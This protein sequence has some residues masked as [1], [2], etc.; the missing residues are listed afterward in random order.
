MSR[1]V[2]I[3]GNQYGKWL[4]IGPYRREKKQTKWF[5]RC[6]GCDQ[7][8]QWVAG[9]TLKNG[10]STG[11]RQC[12]FK[13]TGKKNSTHGQ[14]KSRL[15]NVFCNIIAR[16]EVES[17]I[18][19][20]RYGGRGIKLCPEWRRDFEAFSAYVGEPPTADHEIDRIDNNG[21]YEPGNVRWN[22]VKENNRN[23]RS[24]VII[25]MDGKSQCLI[26]WAEEYGVPYK[27]LHH[28][29]RTRGLDLLTAI[30]KLK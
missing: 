18:N 11:C 10:E 29:V 28:L 6:T 22:T 27:K 24:N 16:T 23:K 26:E 8:E 12:G 19:Y 4:V 25:E 21:N 2:D 15:Y 9:S 20:E 30:N 1:L 3:T 7:V 17:S 13:V 5:C 14:S